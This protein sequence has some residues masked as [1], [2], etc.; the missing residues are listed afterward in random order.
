MFRTSNRRRVTCLAVPGIVAG[1]VLA[2][3][4]RWKRSP[5]ASHVPHIPPYAATIS[6]GTLEIY[7]YGEDLY[8]A[9]LQAIEQAQQRIWFEN[10]IWKGDRV[11]QRFKHALEQA[12]ERG[13]EVYVVFDGFANLVVPRRFKRFPPPI[14]TLEFRIVP[15]LWRLLSPRSYGRDHRKIVLVDD[16]VGFVGGYNIGAVYATRWRDTHVRL[17]GPILWEVE[18]ACLDFWAVHCGERLPHLVKADSSIWDGRV[19]IHRNDP[20]K[21]A[22]PIRDMYLAAIDR[23]QRQIL[24]TFGYFIPDRNMLQEL[25]EAVQRGVDVR[26][27]MPERSNHP[28]VDWVA[29]AYVDELLAGGIRIFLYQ[30]A[31][32]HAKTATIDGQWTTIGTANIDRLSLLGNYEINLEVYDKGVAERME[33]IFAQ[34]VSNAR[35]LTL[36][37]WKQRPFVAKVGEHLVVPLRVLL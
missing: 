12:A 32:L 29:R 14:R 20:P 3:R 7:S 21:L 8:D 30:H 34:D 17:T 25:L 35:E 27:L 31:M 2:L 36:D 6:G 28:L 26:V 10:F 11:G 16:T 33:Y 18:Q 24:L 37:Q 1:A 4:A 9:M 13:V 19:R 5:Q 22:Y 15:R 23:A